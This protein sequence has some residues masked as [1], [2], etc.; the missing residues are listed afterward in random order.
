MGSEVVPASVCTVGENMV[1]RTLALGMMSVIRQIDLLIPSRMPLFLLFGA[2]KSSINSEK[3]SG[4][5]VF[6][7]RLNFSAAKNRLG[8]TSRGT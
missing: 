2:D 8:L 1:R 3:L 5:F 6:S 7:S 4:Y